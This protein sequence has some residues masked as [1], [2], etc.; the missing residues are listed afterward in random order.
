MFPHGNS[1][2]SNK[3]QHLYEIR[4]KQENNIFKYGIS[5]S[6]IEA[7][8]LS[9]RVRTQITILNLASGWERF[10]GKILIRNIEGRQKAKEIERQFIETY[11]EKY[12][13]KPRGNR[14]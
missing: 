14:R 12:G 10:Y 7:D 2:Q 4:D 13:E 9:K 3:I 8:D 5:D 1:N 11:E 6:T